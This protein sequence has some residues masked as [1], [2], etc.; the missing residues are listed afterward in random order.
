VVICVGYDMVE[1]HPDVWNP[2]G[3]KII[4][5]I[6]ALPAE[7]DGRYIL[8]VG[9]LG[10]IGTSLRSLALTAK[11]QKSAPFKAVRDALVADRSEHAQ[12]TGFPIKPQKIVWDLREVLAPDDI[13]ISDVGAHKMW[14]SRMYRAER[15]NTCIISNG[16]AAMGIA[17][18]GALAAKLAY[19]QRKVVAV[20]GDAGFMMNSQEIETALRMNTPFVVLIW[21]DAEY[22]LITWH[23]LRHFGRPSHITFKN[24]DFVKYAESF[25]AKGYRLESAAELVPTLNKA[26]ADNT[27][28]IIDCPVDYSE[29]M[30][31]TERLKNMRSPF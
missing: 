2:L 30:K 28:V 25:G 11:A 5:H 10:D 1:Y 12:D 16:F 3:D 9:V 29:N 19:P 8:A 7:V 26:F 27:V 13:V 21:N 15:P 6:D 14:M 23:Q 22:G 24:P 20:T 17:V 18:P 4:V 31:L